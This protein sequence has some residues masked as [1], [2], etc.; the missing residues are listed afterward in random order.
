VQLT[1][2]TA[3]F[4]SPIHQEGVQFRCKVRFDH[5][6][7]S[8]RTR[9]L[10]FPSSP[11]QAAIDALIPKFETDQ[12]AAEYN[13]AVAAC[14]RGESPT[15]LV[16]THGFVWHTQQQLDAALLNA[17]ARTFG[18]RAL[19][20]SPLLIYYPS[21]AYVASLIPEMSEADVTAW[22]ATLAP[23]QTGATAA[24]TYQAPIND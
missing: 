11:D 18:S 1:T 19:L 3:H 5:H 6:G 13:E 16:A 2:T 12:K 23:M 15:T 9:W 17:M 10:Y 20:F 24:L 14:E 22:R 4:H 21:D 7:R 8:T